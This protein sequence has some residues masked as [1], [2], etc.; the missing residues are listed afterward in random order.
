MFKIL[1]ILLL[2]TSV[3]LA[4]NL[5]NPPAV[6]EPGLYD[7][8]NV[9]RDNFNNLPITETDPDGTTPGKAGDMLLFRNGSTYY[10]EICVIASENTWQGVKLINTP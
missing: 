4:G 6:K 8:L 9:I 3:C 10:L 2:L 5:R 7:Y 1:L